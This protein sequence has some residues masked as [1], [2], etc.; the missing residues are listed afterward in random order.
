MSEA[1]KEFR[2][3]QIASNSRHVV[4]QLDESHGKN[5]KLRFRTLYLKCYKKVDE[6]KNLRYAKLLSRAV[7]D[8]I[9][10]TSLKN[11]T[12]EQNRCGRL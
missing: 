1:E 7:A 11:L 6:L 3:L 5:V 9:G 4:F 2:Y 10:F 8:G 12:N